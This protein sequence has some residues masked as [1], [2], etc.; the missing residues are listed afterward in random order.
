[1]EEDNKVLNEQISNNNTM[2]AIIICFSRT[3]KIKKQNQDFNIILDKQFIKVL[4]SFI[5][6]NIKL[7][8][9]SK[10]KF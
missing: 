4:Y 6:F 2:L 7:G 5:Q 1:M 8:K 3:K 9:D 10:Q